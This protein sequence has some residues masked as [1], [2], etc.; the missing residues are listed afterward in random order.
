MTGLTEPATKRPRKM[1]REPQSEPASTPTIALPAKPQTKA[2]LVEGLLRA[3]E[4]TSI[5]ELCKATGWLPH[6]CR[7]FLTGLRKKGKG[8]ERGRRGDVTVYK[9]SVSAEPA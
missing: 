3:D 9:L 4:G 7:A 1:T 2:A 8:I 5:A 6:S